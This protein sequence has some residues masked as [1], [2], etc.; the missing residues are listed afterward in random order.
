MIGTDLCCNV[1]LFDDLLRT[2]HAIASRREGCRTFVATEQRWDDVN[3][4]WMSSLA[5]SKMRCVREWP[6]PTSSRLPRPVLCAELVC[7]EDAG[8][9]V[10]GKAPSAIILDVLDVPPRPAGKQEG[11]RGGQ[12]QQAGGGTGKRLHKT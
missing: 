5:N 1:D 4:R 2:I 10:G 11:G 9:D 3:A 12:G 8:G 7:E 6:L